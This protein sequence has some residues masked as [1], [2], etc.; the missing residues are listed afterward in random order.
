M[1][2]RRGVRGSGAGAGE[3]AGA[4]AVK[5]QEQVEVLA[6]MQEQTPMGEQS[7]CRSSCGPYAM[8]RSDRRENME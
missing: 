7:T 1:E 5:V 2:T 8:E 4:G 3:G 6:H